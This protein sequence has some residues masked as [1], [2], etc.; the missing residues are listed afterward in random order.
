MSSRRRHHGP[1]A[2]GAQAEGLFRRPVECVPEVADGHVVGEDFIAKVGGVADALDDAVGHAHG[3][4][5]RVHEL[6]RFG[7]GDIGPGDLVTEAHAR[8]ARQSGSPS[9]LSEM[10]STRAPGPIAFCSNQRSNAS[11]AR[12]SWRSAGT[13]SSDRQETV[14]SPM[15]LPEWASIG[16][17]RKAARLGDVSG[18]DP[19]KPGPCALADR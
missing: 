14:K 11:P 4:A 13:R 7:A 8:S 17:Q 15:I 19:V 10:F 16:R 18:H 12:R 3:H 5:A 2:E 1:H 9:A 6:E